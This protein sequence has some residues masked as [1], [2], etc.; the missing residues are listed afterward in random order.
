[1]IFIQRVDVCFQCSVYQHHIPVVKLLERRRNHC[2]PH[3]GVRVRCAWYNTVENLNNGWPDE[4]KNQKPIAQK[5]PL[6]LY[7]GDRPLVSR[8]SYP[9]SVLYLTEYFPPV[10]LAGTSSQGA[11]FF[12]LM[13]GAVLGCWCKSASRSSPIAN[14]TV[15]TKGQKVQYVHIMGDV[16]PVLK[17]KYGIVI[18]LLFFF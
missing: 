2:G 11:Y 4:A 16:L 5:N 9:L 8:N 10:L 13:Q 15:R 1:M 14:T 12:L 17:K 3:G 18:L 7:A 6:P